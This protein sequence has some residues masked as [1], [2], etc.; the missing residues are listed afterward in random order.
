MNQKE[1]IWKYATA[2]VVV[3]ILLNPEMAELA[4]FIDAVGLEMFILFLE[5]QVLSILGT[6]LYTPI[7]S[8]LM[9]VKQL[10]VSYFQW[11]TWKSI[12][13]TPECL[14]LATQ[15]QALL[16]VILVFSAAISI[17]VN[18]GLTIG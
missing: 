17:A 16:M 3:F 2:F 15:S 6:L 12:K 8:F 9:R 5:V 1:K 10:R 11:A 4:I 18:N 13:E 14:I 7:K